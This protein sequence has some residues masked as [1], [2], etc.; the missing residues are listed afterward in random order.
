[1]PQVI[2]K[3]GEVREIPDN[4]LFKFL[5]KNSHSIKSQK[6]RS[7]RSAFKDNLATATNTK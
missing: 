4:E 6:G 5:Q 2:M 7:R 1:M 3:T